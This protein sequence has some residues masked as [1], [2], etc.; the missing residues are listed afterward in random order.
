[1]SFTES[2]ASQLLTTA[3]ASGR[4]PHALLVIGDEAAG[5]HNLVLNLV[6]LI[7]TDTKGDSLESIHDEYMRLIRPRSKSRKILIDDVRSVEPFLQQKADIGRR[8]IVII[9][10]AER[11]NDEAANAFLKTLEEPPSQTLIILVTSQPEQ[12]LPTIISR[13][14][15]VPLFSPGGNIRLTP[16]QEELL[17]AW[18][19]AAS[20]MGNDLGALSFRSVFLE[21][22]GRRKA[23]ITRRMTLSLKE[24]SKAIS[25]GTDTSNW[26]S[27]NKDLNVA[28]IETEY[29]AE[30][31][32]AI[33]LMILWFGQAAAITSGAPGI[34]PMHEGIVQL[35]QNMPVPEILQRMK[36][37]EQLRSDLKF[38]VHEGLCMDVHLLE[39]L[40]NLNS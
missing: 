7:N 33:D 40:G 8:K 5:T 38:N 11:M 17:P 14:I 25:Q 19:D 20:R 3:Y 6:R 16:V 13:C 24:E 35:A 39:A 23:E 34:T 18:A 9:L 26:E 12:L 21:L 28:L 10:E 31:D 30:R 2:Q 27:Q 1:M 4:F 29:L 22:L 36:G 32:Q 15:N 37:V